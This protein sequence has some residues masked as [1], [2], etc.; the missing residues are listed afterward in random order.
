[1]TPNNSHRL[2]HSFDLGLTKKMGPENRLKIETALLLEI[3]SALTLT[4]S[5]KTGS[6]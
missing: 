2:L 5:S 4:G 1:M 3:T 6:C